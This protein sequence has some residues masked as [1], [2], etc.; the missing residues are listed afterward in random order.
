M[1]EI[2]YLFLSSQFL[3]MLML[4]SNILKFQNHCPYI[5]ICCMSRIDEIISYNILMPPH[6]VVRV[7]PVRHSA[8]CSFKYRN[9]ELI[10]VDIAMVVSRK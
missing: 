2:G 10:L 7:L 9:C 8:Y 1:Y 4:N 5:L 6:C 3:S